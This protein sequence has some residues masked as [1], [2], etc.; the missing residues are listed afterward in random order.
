MQNALTSMLAG[1]LSPQAFCDRVEA[2]AEK[3]RNDDSI[4]KHKL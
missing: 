2:A 3:T 4:P 1:D